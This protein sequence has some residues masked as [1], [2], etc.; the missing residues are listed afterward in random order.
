[1]LLAFRHPRCAFLHVPGVCVPHTAHGT[2]L[3]RVTTEISI[4]ASATSRVQTACSTSAYQVSPADHF[5]DPQA[6]NHYGH[7]KSRGVPPPSASFLP[8]A[9]LTSSSSCRLVVFHEGKAYHAA[10][11]PAPFQAPFPSSLPRFST[12]RPEPHLFGP[13]D[14]FPGGVKG[15]VKVP[16]N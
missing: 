9:L 2:P 8:P 16:L 5:G 10:L 14:V 12:F 6:D 4:S 15:M 11:L 1:M 3:G 13:S 7:R